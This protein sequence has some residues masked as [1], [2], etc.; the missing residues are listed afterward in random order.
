MELGASEYYYKDATTR[1]NRVVTP[2]QKLQVDLP[3]Q[4]VVVMMNNLTVNVIEAPPPQHC[5]KR[6]GKITLCN[7]NRRFFFLF[8]ITAYLHC[9]KRELFE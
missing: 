7:R 1:Q 3:L 2:S 8:E 5:L 6:F 9:I 4:Q